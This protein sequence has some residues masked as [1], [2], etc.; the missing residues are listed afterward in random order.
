MPDRFDTEYEVGQDNLRKF[1]MDIHHPV[2]WIAAVLVL[3]F[4][5]GTLMAPEAAKTAFDGAKG[6]SITN[7]DWLFMLGG[8]IFVLF[9][10]ALVLL[11]VGKIRIGGPEAKPEFGLLSWFA[12]TS[13]RARSCGRIA[14]T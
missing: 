12:M 3:I 1:G 13:M 4:V 14:S 6:W 5:V 2:F 8:N 10:L 7:F 9:S 11:P